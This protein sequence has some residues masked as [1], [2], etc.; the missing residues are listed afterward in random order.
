[1]GMEH[2]HGHGL[3]M[4]IGMGISLGMSIF[5]CLASDETVGAVGPVARERVEGGAA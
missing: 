1:M 4:G 2:G 5:A 3:G